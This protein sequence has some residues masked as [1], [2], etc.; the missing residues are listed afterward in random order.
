MCIS[1]ASGC[2]NDN[3]TSISAPEFEQQIKADSV[4][5][6]DVRTPQ[7]YAEGHI[8]GAVNID[9]QSDDFQQLA[10]KNYRKTPLSSS[11]AVAD[12]AH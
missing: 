4:Q 8:A 5:L 10:D 7:E 11:T 1:Q 6:L 3:I 9:V 12:A 2:N